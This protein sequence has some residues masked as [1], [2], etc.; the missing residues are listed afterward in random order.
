MNYRQPPHDGYPP[1]YYPS[2]PHS[3]GHDMLLG[4]ML[5]ELKQGQSSIVH[6]L[7]TQTEVL[8]DIR[9]QLRD[10]SR[11]MGER[12]PQVAQ[13]SAQVATATGGS[14]PSSPPPKSDMLTLRD[15][16]QIVA[17]GLV[18]GAALYTK[19]PLNEALPLVGKLFGF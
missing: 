12:L 16:V 6:A 17:A 4:S 5:G 15:W 14:V 2:S 7:G 11:L 9:D 10:N 18:L 8:S 3:N 1:S 19:M 13:A